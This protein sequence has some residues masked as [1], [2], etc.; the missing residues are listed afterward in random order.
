MC[1]LHQPENECLVLCL[2]LQEGLLC[3]TI[4]LKVSMGD[5][6]SCA[7]LCMWHLCFSQEALLNLLACVVLVTCTLDSQ[8]QSKMWNFLLIHV[9][10]S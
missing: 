2:Q 10:C 8:E 4:F 7:F 9:A 3:I 6:F 5:F 1:H